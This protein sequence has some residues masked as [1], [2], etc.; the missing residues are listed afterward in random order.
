[1][2]ILVQTATPNSSNRVNGHVME[3]DIAI[4]DPELAASLRPIYTK[5]LSDLNL[6]PLERFESEKLMTAVLEAAAATGVPHPLNSRS[7]EG[8]LVGYSYA[9]NCLPYLPLDVKVWVAIYTWLATL[10]DEPDRAGILEDMSLFQ[11]RWVK[12]L[13]QPTVLLGAFADQIRLTYEYWHPLVANMIVTASF[14]FVTATA[15]GAR[16]DIKGKTANPSKGGQLFPWFMRS[17]DGVG[18]AYAWFPFPKTM[19]P[20]LDVPI[21]AIED[22]NRFLAFTNDVLSFYKEQLN[23]EKDNYTNKIAGYSQ[24]SLVETLKEASEDVIACVRRIEHVLAGNEEY[25]KAWYLHKTGYIHMHTM[26][27]RY[28]LWQLDIG[29]KPGEKET[30]RE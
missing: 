2:T 15:L 29:E 24:K 3:G 6:P 1:M 12:G 30:L 27:S 13:P 21:E 22:M 18:E 25:A 5:F 14:G 16:D 17:R 9:D 23:G 20:N 10:C 19:F 28:K 4:E 8:L 11:E 7:Y 26:R